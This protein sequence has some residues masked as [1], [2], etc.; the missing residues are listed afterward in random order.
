MWVWG[1]L[2]AACVQEQSGFGDKGGFP[3][4]SPAGNATE[5]PPGGEPFK[6]GVEYVRRVVND[7]GCLSEGLLIKNVC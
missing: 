4:L 2:L 1:M 5:A 7:G 6:C 3:P